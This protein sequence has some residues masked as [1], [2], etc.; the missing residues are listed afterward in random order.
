M[1]PTFILKLNFN[2]FTSTKSL[3]FVV[4]NADSTLSQ[5]YY[6]DHERYLK[7]FF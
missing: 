5:K 6:F 7:C 3:C 4:K 2:I 1:Y